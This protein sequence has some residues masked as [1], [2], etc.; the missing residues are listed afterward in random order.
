MA[1][2]ACVGTNMD[3]LVKQLSIELDDL[4]ES[5]AT[6]DSEDLLT[7]VDTKL[8]QKTSQWITNGMS[9]NVRVVDWPREDYTRPVSSLNGAILTV[10]S[11]FGAAIE[12]AATY[13]LHRLFPRIEKIRAL[14]QALFMVFPDVYELVRD[15]SLT[16]VSGLSGYDISELGIWN[17]QP[18]QV[19][20]QL[21]SGDTDYEYY[22]TGN[23]SLLFATATTWL[24]QTFI[25]V[26]SHTITGIKL[27]LSRIGS[28]GPITISIKATDTNGKPT[29]ADL[30]SYTIVDGESLPLMGSEEWKEITF[31]TTTHLQ[32]GTKYAIVVRATQTIPH[33]VTWSVDTTSPTYTRGCALHS[34][35]SGSTWSATAFELMFE[36]CGVADD[37]DELDTWMELH[38]WQ[39]TPD[40]I[41]T[42]G[43][44]LEDGKRLCIVGIRPPQFVIEDDFCW[45]L[46]LLQ[47]FVSIVTAQAAIILWERRI[48]SGLESDV[49]RV[50]EMIQFWEK[51]LAER[52]VRNKMMAPPGQIV[53][54]PLDSALGGITPRGYTDEDDQWEDTE[55]VGMPG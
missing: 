10:A 25:P 24:A 55:Y 19:L 29:G 33:F 2:P 31:S 47:P 7:V 3:T 46:P 36:E 26:V 23:D 22:K 43:E 34:S 42:L 50:K 49:N 8:L 9:I 51:R 20:Y 17:N 5:R 11:A 18:H 35:T 27:L 41:L 6:S 40:G 54:N 48:S 52:R 53:F 44:T 39:V 37:T 15:S 12:A 1:I 45:C 21:N 4:W 38:H 30:C 16:I 32:A 14:K 13:E 28:P